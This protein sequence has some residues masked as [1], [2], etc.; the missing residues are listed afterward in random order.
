MTD[1]SYQFAIRMPNGE[2]FSGY[3]ESL[4]ALSLWGGTRTK[5]VYV[6]DTREEAQQQLDALRQLAADLG[7]ADW[8]GSIVTRVCSPFSSADPARDF[9]DEVDRWLDGDASC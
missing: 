3:T 8:L 6:Y 1:L 5:T 9:A 7:V 2:L 4:F